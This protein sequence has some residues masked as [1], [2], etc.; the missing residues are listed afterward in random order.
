MDFGI[1]YMRANREVESGADGDLDRFQ[2]SA[3]Y[4]F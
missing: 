4:A 2:F 1:E 3:K